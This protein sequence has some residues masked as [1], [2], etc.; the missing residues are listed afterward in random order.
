MTARTAVLQN[1]RLDTSDYSHKVIIMFG[2]PYAIDI[3]LNGG[4]QILRYLTADNEAH[5]W[6]RDKRM[7]TSF[8]TLSTLSLLF[9]LIVLHATCREAEVSMAK[10]TVAKLPLPR[11]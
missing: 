3:R 4:R 5:T 11:Q 8:M 9:L 7:S 6:S 1:L 10:W 2:S